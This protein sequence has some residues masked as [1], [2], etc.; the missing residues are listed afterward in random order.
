[1]VS[2]MLNNEQPEKRYEKKGFR[3]A[4]RRQLKKLCNRYNLRYPPWLDGSELTVRQY[5]L[6]VRWFIE[7]FMLQQAEHAQSPDGDGLGKVAL[8]KIRP[9]MVSHNQGFLLPLVLAPPLGVKM[10]AAAAA[11]VRVSHVSSLPHPQLLQNLQGQLEIHLQVL[12]SLAT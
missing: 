9:G 3:A 1:M 6:R 11:A 12:Q 7:D 8:H 5:K 2:Q 10:T 4:V